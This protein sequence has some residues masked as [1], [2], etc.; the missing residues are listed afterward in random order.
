MAKQ[1][2]ILMFLVLATVPAWADVA[3]WQLREVRR[4]QG[5]L[6]YCVMDRTFPD[7]RHLNLARDPGGLMNLGFVLPDQHFTAQQVV[8]LQISLGKGKPQALQARALSPTMLIVDLP[9]QAAFRPQWGQ[10]RRLRVTGLD[11]PQLFPLG[12]APAVW[13]EL[14]ECVQKQA[15]AIPAMVLPLLEQAGLAEGLQVIPPPTILSFVDFAW[16]RGTINGG[17][18]GFDP[19]PDFPTAVRGQ[20]AVLKNYCQ[21]LWSQELRW[22]LALGNVK[23]QQW[24]LSCT[25]GGRDEVMAMVFHTKGDGTARYYTHVGTGADRAAIIAATD[26]LA[27]VLAR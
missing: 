20:L 24:V 8:T 17:T 22:N 1:F 6:D 25:G 3:D 23:Q 14:E 21:G 16:K 9:D 7:G 10:A 13:A 2:I 11:K 18:Q 27:L 4:P 15:L 12:D 19:A 5:S 26:A